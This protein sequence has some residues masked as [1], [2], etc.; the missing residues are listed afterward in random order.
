M[1]QVFLCI[2]FFCS[3]AVEGAFTTQQN[4]L[5]P[6]NHHLLIKTYEEQ[7]N[8]FDNLNRSNRKFHYLSSSSSSS[9]TLNSPLFS[10]KQKS[11][12]CCDRRSTATN[13][14]TSAKYNRKFI[15]PWIILLNSIIGIS[16]A[17]AATSISDISTEKKVQEIA[18]KKHIL[19]MITSLTDK[20]KTISLQVIE[21]T[22]SSRLPNLFKS[23]VE[24]RTPTDIIVAEPQFPIA[25]NHSLQKS[26]I[27]LMMSLLNKLQHTLLSVQ[28]LDRKIIKRSI[29]YLVFIFISLGSIKDVVQTRNRQ[30]LDATSEW[31][32]YADY[33]SAR[34]RALFAL[35][36]RLT[37]LMIITRIVNSLPGG[38]YSILKVNIKNEAGEEAISVENNVIN[39]SSTNN[40]M[41]DDD[42]WATKKAKQLR[43]NSGDNLAEGLLR[44]G[45]LYIKIGQIISCREKLLPDEWKKSLE[46]LQDRVPA[47]SGR[48]AL[49]LAYQAYDGDAEKFHSLFS[50]FE[51]IPLAAASLGQVHRAKLKSNNNTVAI[52]LQRAR[53]R[54]IYDKDLALMNK[55]A[56]IVD[57]FAGKLGQVGGVKQSWEDIFKDAETILYRE[58]DYRSEAKN[59]IRFASDFGIGKDGN[60][61]VC[62]AQSLDGKVLPSAAS[63]MRTP[64]VYED[65]STEK[66]LVMEYVPSIKI[67]E[68][69]Q[70]SAA[71]VSK[72][73][74]QY[75]AE[76]L[77]R[78][79]LRQFCVNKFFS[80][81]PQ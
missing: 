23:V 15:V 38:E 53:L 45:P 41:S 20:F 65:V 69:K 29:I 49:E 67:S 5:V 61:I 32:R 51:D 1:W 25:E 6:Q 56:K 43:K 68:D 8:V 54:E 62:T 40:N 26:I 50:E 12:Q 19:S 11:L 76:C 47:K 3:V 17:I 77:A 75:L 16:K 80:T 9:G 79:Y 10:A 72:D 13:P 81:D 64:Y 55:M 52:K 31:G 59:A 66:I 46:R 73:E 4:R 22:K 27:L 7:G 14:L 57:T 28:H 30:K 74:K 2:F 63:W 44:L 35:M 71:G 58:I 42:S 70:L 37:F 60:A 18:F 39:G 48:D 24:R 36:G 78:A 21:K 33:P 34:G